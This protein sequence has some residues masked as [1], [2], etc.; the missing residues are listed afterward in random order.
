[1]KIAFYAPLKSPGHARPSG[2]RRLARNFIAALQAS[3]FETEV[4]SELRAWEGDG[5]A[6][7]QA[8]IEAHGKREAARI[9]ADCRARTDADRPRAW[10]T[11]HLYHKAPD[12][13]G[14]AVADALGV[15]YIVA[16]A[17]VAAKQCGGAWARGFNESVA[18]VAR[19][20]LIFNLNS[21]D[22]AGLSAHAGDAR[23]VELKPFTD[24]P[25]AAPSPKEKTRRDL[26]ARYGVDADAN[27]LVCVAM[28]RGGDKRKSYHILADALGQTRRDDWRL[29][30]AGDGAAEAEVR[31][32]FAQALPAGRVHFLGRLQRDAV[33][34]LLQ[35][36]DAFVWPAVNEA[37]GMAALEAMAC[38]VPVVA[39]RW[40]GGGIGDIVEHGVTGVLVDRPDEDGGAA[41]AAA[42]ERL[43]GDPVKRAEMASAA[44]DKFNRLH[45]LDHAAAQ[46]GKAILPLLD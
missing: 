27:W 20:S 3:G 9:I 8:E 42:V 16:E 28:L 18:A 10:F 19:A 37:F 23:I 24:A 13:L 32:D 35:A 4:A 34:A 11:Y 41:F 22:L 46:I 36:G 31:A 21:N 30:I 6:R 33:F 25:P 12:W 39:G 44:T 15:P 7:R 1:M 43:L 17:S 40:R 26:A 5:D 29:L 2:D 14:P 38:G 45:R